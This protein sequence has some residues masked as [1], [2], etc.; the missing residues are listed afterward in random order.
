M[1]IIRLL[2]VAHFIV[3]TSICFAQNVVRQRTGK[4]FE[5]TQ[6]PAIPS[7]R[8]LLAEMKTYNPRMY[9]QYQ[10]GKKMQRTGIIMT[11]TGGGCI[12]IGTLFSIIPDADRT[13]ITM[14]PHVVETGGNNS[15]LRKTGTV[16]M[17]AGAV[18]L[19]AGLPVMI[20]G[21]KKKKQTLQDYKNQYYLSQQPSSYFQ[22]NVYPNKV[23]IA[24]MF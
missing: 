24:Y 10:S 23:G 14:G 18:C 9:F 5:N 2:L 15:N 12:V 13:T 11:G 17:V 22:M 6:R 8:T 1:K 20:V 3:I 4:Y 7:D 19:S 21:S 16:L